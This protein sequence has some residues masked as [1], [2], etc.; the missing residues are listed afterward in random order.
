[1]AIPRSET[2]KQALLEAA[3][4]VVAV[5][6]VAAPTSQIAKEA[7]VAE[8]TLFRYFPTKDDLLNDLFIYLLQSLGGS[9]LSEYDPDAPLRIRAQTV[10]E[11]Y[12][13]WGI[14]NM[15]GHSAM[16][17]L[18]VSERIRPQTRSAAMELCSGVRGVFDTCKFEGI[19]GEA[20]VE[21]AEEVLSA[22]AQVTIA[23]A[24][25]SPIEAATYIRAGFAVMW[26]GIHGG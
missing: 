15:N 24:S 20:S 26:S 19:R 10:W 23:N 3:M 25:R 8:G 11:N 22:I 21:F 1:M 16:T 9:L 4:Q 18:A 2:K 12:I 7:K 14:R 6:G 13:S 17:Q 5:H